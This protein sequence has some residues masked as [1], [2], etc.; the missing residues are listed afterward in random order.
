M[1]CEKFVNYKPVLNGE[2]IRIAFMFQVASFWP[3]WES[4]YFACENDSRINVRLYLVTDNVD[5]AWQLR[6]AK[7]FLEQNKLQYVEFSDAD[8][9]KYSAHIAVLQTPYDILQRSPHLYSRTLTDKGIRVVYIPYGIEIAD[10]RAA[11]HD[12][13]RETVI[14]NAWRIYTF[15][16]AATLEYKKYCNNSSSVRAVGLPRFDAYASQAR[17]A[18]LEQANITAGNRQIIVW[19]THF[20][21]TIDTAVGKCQV[22]PHL[23]EY[24]HFAKTISQYADKLFFIFMPHPRF[25]DDAVDKENNRKSA[26]LLKVLSSTDNTFIDRADD[27]RPS[28][29]S[30]KAIITDRSAL[31][32]EAALV[33]VPILYM[34]NPDYSEPMFPPLS[35]LVD[36]YSQGFYYT[37]MEKFLER[38]LLGADDHQE[39]RRKALS[40]CIP[41][42]DAKSGERVMEDIIS[43]I[44][45]FEPLMTAKRIVLFGLGFLYK[46]IMSYYSFPDSIEIVA[47]SDND[48]TKW[49]MEFGGVKCV[50]PYEINSIE[51]DKIIIMTTNVFAEQIYKQLYFDVEI[52]SSKIESCEFLAV[53][54]DKE[55]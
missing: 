47:V 5:E 53:W 35:R 49:G 18:S 44:Y 13:F 22:T 20:S 17:L 37:D 39:W 15:S 32:I 14:N 8:F 34:K 25:G 7:S 21:K 23:D 38:I 29:L 30:A 36:S 11:R 45:S 4:F 52:P 10:T 28:L 54:E 50:P 2:C 9:E 31:M 6:T 41:C 19:H 55:Q 3:S 42:L 1:A 24:I 12:H 27:Y 26:E 46:K 43:S 51:F 40:E 48:S 33:D 16:D